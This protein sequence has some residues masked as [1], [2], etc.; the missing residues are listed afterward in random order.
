[1]NGHVIQRVKPAARLAAPIALLAL[2]A[3]C[4][5]ILLPIQQAAGWIRHTIDDGFRGADGVKLGDVNGDGLLDLL[6]PWEGSGAVVVYL[7]PGPLQASRPW[8]AVTVGEVGAVEDAVFV[9]LDTDGRVDVVSCCQGDVQTMYV[10]WAPITPALVSNS[11]AWQTE[12]LPATAGRC[13]W[14]FCEPAQIDGVRGVD[15][16][17]GAK[18]DNGQIGFL[19][20]PANPRNLSAWSWRL[21]AN[22]GWIMSIIPIDLDE[23]GDIDI[24]YSD[25][26]GDDRGCYWL[27]NPGQQL[28]ALLPWWRHRIGT[29]S[30]E[31]M[32]MDL[33]DLD[34]DNRLDAIVATD[35]R[36]L[37]H[38]TPLAN[39]RLPWLA[40]PITW[41]DTFGTGKSVR[42]T[43]IDLDESIDIV[44]ACEN[45]AGRRG[46]GRLS[47][48]D[49]AGLPLWTAE[50]ISD[51][52]GAKF[53]LIQLL[54]VDQD[55]DLDVIATEESS[56]LGVVWYENPTLVP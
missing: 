43:D 11:G 31:L 53:D 3:G 32:F 51:D 2:C 20:A 13:K 9:D 45:A 4:D 34:G 54:D 25:R 28:A 7:N 47:Q 5:Q 39:P 40:T 46:V 52:T 18:D 26:K 23:D 30:D 1:M 48:L 12:A 19:A 41:P 15:L 24:V 38:F 42:L 17:A 14:M 37:L 21:V 8:P 10:H 6:V 55:G 22:A 50:S 29:S 44:F 35:Q 36:E 16:V 56:G 33:G 49:L 27:E